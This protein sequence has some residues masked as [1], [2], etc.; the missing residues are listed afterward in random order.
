MDQGLQEKI[1]ELQKKVARHFEDG[2]DEAGQSPPIVKSP[3]QPTA[4]ECE[5]H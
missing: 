1:E 4:A 3:Q 5:K 2:S